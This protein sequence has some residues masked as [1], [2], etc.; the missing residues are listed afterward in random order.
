MDAVVTNVT[1]SLRLKMGP[2]LTTEGKLRQTGS[3]T[4][5]RQC[6]EAN[7]AGAVASN[8]GKQTNKSAEGWGSNTLPYCS[9][10]WVLKKRRNWYK[11]LHRTQKAD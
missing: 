10:I 4:A 5:S 3:C 7:G 9:A 11:S 1:I 8:D 6:V 2:V